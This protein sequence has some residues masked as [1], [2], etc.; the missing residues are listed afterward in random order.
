MAAMPGRITTNGMNILGKAAIT[1]VRRA[2]EVE[3]CN[4]L[5]LGWNRS[6]AKYLGAVQE[7]ASGFCTPE[8]KKCE[9]QFKELVKARSGI[10]NPAPFMSCA[11]SVSEGRD[12]VDNHIFRAP[13][14]V[15]ITKDCS[16]AI[17]EFPPVTKLGQQS[18]QELI[19]ACGK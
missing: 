13:R 12:E 9:T 10:E 16:E 15:E 14:M 3:H 19:D 4:D 17:Y 1:G 7:L 5:K 6:V 8:G 2:A 11:Q 18:S